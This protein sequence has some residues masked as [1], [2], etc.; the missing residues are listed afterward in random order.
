MRFSGSRLSFCSYPLRRLRAEADTVGPFGHIVFNPR[1]GV[2]PS[3]GSRLL[4]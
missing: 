1:G 2:S 4:C 3:D